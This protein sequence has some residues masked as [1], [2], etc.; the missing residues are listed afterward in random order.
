MQAPQLCRAR[1]SAVLLMA[2]MQGKSIE[3][4]RP[5]IVGPEGSNVTLAIKRGGNQLSGV[6]FVFFYDAVVPS[7]CFP[8]LFFF[9]PAGNRLAQFNVT[10]A[11]KPAASAA[12]AAQK[13]L[14]QEQ[15]APA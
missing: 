2:A 15:R 5:W 9:L 10:L 13:P 8:P 14:Y 7:C 3:D 6:S 12:A 4:I 1:A 11:R